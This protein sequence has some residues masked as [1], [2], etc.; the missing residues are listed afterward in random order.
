MKVYQKIIVAGFSLFYSVE[1]YEDFYYFLLEN[2]HQ[3]IP[4]ETDNMP[5][6]SGLAVTGLD[7]IF[8]FIPHEFPIRELLLWL[9]DNLN[10]ALTFAQIERA[11]ELY[12]QSGR[13]SLFSDGREVNG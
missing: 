8:T 2:E 9:H 4:R 11:L 12:A 10:P 13:T 3:L 1:R 6:V 7:K 5:G